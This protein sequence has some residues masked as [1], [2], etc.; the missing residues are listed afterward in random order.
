MTSTQVL[1]PAKGFLNSWDASAVNCLSFSKLCSIGFKDCLVNHIPPK[2]VNPDTKIPP[3]II[4]NLNCVKTI[5]TASVDSL[6]R[7]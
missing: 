1:I 7:I 5:S 6:I 4:P 3:N 2:A